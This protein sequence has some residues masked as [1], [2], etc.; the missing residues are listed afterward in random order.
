M[1]PP[2]RTWPFIFISEMAETRLF[3]TGVFKVILQ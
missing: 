2:K 1:A 3:L